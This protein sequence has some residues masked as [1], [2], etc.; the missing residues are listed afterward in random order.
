MFNSLTGPVTAAGP[1]YIR[2]R[3]AGIEWHL[4]AS[5]R[6]VQ[7]LAGTSGK[8]RVPVYLYHRED[9]MRMYGFADEHE[10]RVFEELLTVSGIGPRQA[11]K[12][13]T[14]V[15]AAELQQ[16]VER[17]DV[18]G[19]SSLP[20]VG[21]K[22]AEKMVFTLKGTLVTASD[23]AAEPASDIVRALA[24]MGFDERQAAATVR[25]VLSGDDL[26][27]EAGARESEVLRRAIVELS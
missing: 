4:E 1:D 9:V 22:T 5:G 19:L 14:G 12:I 26:P 2:I 16:L 21:K 3:T 13:L 18:K 17:E 23:G 6:T 15:T 10:R 11:L 7:R 8:V 27:E 25:A 24:E 20:G